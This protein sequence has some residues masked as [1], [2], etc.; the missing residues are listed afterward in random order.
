M[1]AADEQKQALFN[2]AS[3]GLQVKG[4]HLD[5]ALAKLEQSQMLY[6]HD[7]HPGDAVL[8]MSHSCDLHQLC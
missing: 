7:P 1:D 5:H 8:N 3:I 6:A 4:M 2:P